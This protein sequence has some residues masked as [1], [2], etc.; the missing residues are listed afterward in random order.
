M[1]NIAPPRGTPEELQAWNNMMDTMVTFIKASTTLMNTITSKMMLTQAAARSV[2]ESQ[3]CEES[4]EACRPTPPRPICGVCPENAKKQEKSPSK[5]SFQEPAA[6][7]EPK[8]EGEATEEGA[9][10]DAPAE[11]NAEKTNDADAEKKPDEEASPPKKSSSNVAAEA[12]STDAKKCICSTVRAK[13]LEEKEK[14]EDEQL[15]EPKDE[16]IKTC[17]CGPTDGNTDAEM[18]EMIEKLAKAQAEITELQSQMARLQRL[19]STKRFGPHG[20]PNTASLYKE[21]MRNNEPCPA[22]P[23]ARL[24]NQVARPRPY[25]Q[26]YSSKYNNSTMALAIGPGSAKPISGNYRGQGPLPSNFP[27]KSTCNAQNM[28]QSMVP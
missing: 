16:I 18:R 10:P 8:P 27:C 14:A 21:I 24:Q 12:S 5:V 19:S 11:E 26:D 15:N 7:E 1:N 4:C 2:E 22:S 20:G 23:S 3:E 9:K 17:C 13:R 28:Q 25:Q 6:A